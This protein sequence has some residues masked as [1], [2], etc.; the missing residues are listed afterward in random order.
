MKMLAPRVTNAP[1]SRIKT[2]T[3]A[4]TR[5]R[6]SVWMKIRD[7]IMRRDLG[8]CQSCVRAGKLTKATQVDHIIPL[9][10]GGTDAMENLEAICT[11]CH[12][13][14]TIPSYVFGNITTVNIA[15]FLSWCSSLQVMPSITIGNVYASNS[16]IISN[17]YSLKR[18]LMP[19]KFSFSVANAKMS[20]AALNE[21]YSNYVPTYR[22]NPSTKGLTYSGQVT[23][24][25][26][27][28]KKAVGSSKNLL[29]LHEQ[30]SKQTMQAVKATHDNLFGLRLAQ[31]INPKTQ[32]YVQEL[33]K[34]QDTIDIDA[35]DV[36]ELKNAF[37]IIF[38]IK[39]L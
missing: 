36:P 16:S 38:N 27:G 13:I 31:N 22:L 10:Q 20:A 35:E 14:K 17:C 39:S 19:L 4:N 2:N 3:T 33:K 37:K 29:P 18:M 12:S 15:S 25:K 8:I 21:M 1:T 7:A 23:D 9:H 26:T 5:T 11:N 28:I 32:Q 34:I 24:I 6:G 30:I